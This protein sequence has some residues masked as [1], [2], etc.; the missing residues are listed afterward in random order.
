MKTD[1]TI[2][3]EIRFVGGGDAS[4]ECSKYFVSPDGN[5]YL[6]TGNKT[7]FFNAHNTTFVAFT[8]T[9]PK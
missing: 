9:P 5:G 3:Y 7:L 2:A 1:N 6:I 8:E 4:G